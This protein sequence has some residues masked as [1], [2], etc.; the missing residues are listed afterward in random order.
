M[1]PIS[2]MV[3]QHALRRLGHLGRMAEGTMAQKL[4]FA[5]APA[6]QFKR[7]AGGSGCI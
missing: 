7:V 4:L 6:G 5:S 3:R 2:E 1:R